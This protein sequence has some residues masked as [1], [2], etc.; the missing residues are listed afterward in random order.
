MSYFKL[1]ISIAAAALVRTF[2]MDGCGAIYFI[3]LYDV[4]ELTP[5]EARRLN[6]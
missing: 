2:D 1:Q 3:C 5:R 4:R 6:L